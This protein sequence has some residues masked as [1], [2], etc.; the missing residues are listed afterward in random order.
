[1]GQWLWHVELGTAP[2][3][4]MPPLK[5]EA[6]FKLVEHSGI[7]TCSA[8]NSALLHRLKITNCFG[9]EL[10]QP[11]ASKQPEP[12]HKGISPAAATQQSVAACVCML[13]GPFLLNKVQPWRWKSVDT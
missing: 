2:P 1:M 8:G 4:S 6:D 5:S 13:S 3:I 7:P 12:N 9:L 10:A 11:P